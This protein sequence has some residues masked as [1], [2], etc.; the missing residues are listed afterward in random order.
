[1]AVTIVI[2]DGTGK[3]DAN[4]YISAADADL[5]FD[6][7]FLGDAWRALV[8]ADKKARLLI[9]ASRIL[10]TGFDF[11]GWKTTN[12]Q[13]L[14]WPR[15]LAKDK[16]Q[17][18][19]AFWRVPNAYLFEFFDPNSVPTIVKQAVCEMARSLLSSDDRTADV[20]GIG[21]KRFEIFEGIKVEFDASN[22]RPILPEFVQNILMPLGQ[23]RGVGF[24]NA[25][26][27]RA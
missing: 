7:N 10:D 4:S 26:I 3:A 15:I 2:E 13:A 12:I 20:Q 21:L 24:S 17:Y 8:D 18:S 22:Q 16:N 1:M 23:A 14:Q 6:G 9:T 11:I 27:S 5:Y 19:G 25:R